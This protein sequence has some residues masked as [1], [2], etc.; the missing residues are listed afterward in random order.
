LHVIG[1][2][3]IAQATHFEGRWPWIEIVCS[4]IPF[5]VGEETIFH[6]ELEEEDDLGTAHAN[7]IQPLV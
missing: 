3:A 2:L 4:L 7:N 5:T 6:T 1:L